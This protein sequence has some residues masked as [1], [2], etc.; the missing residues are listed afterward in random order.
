MAPA[1]ISASRNDRRMLP[2]SQLPFRS[3]LKAAGAQKPLILRA[4]RRL[5]AARA[6]R[7]PYCRA[8]LRTKFRRVVTNVPNQ[9]FR[10][11][12]RTRRNQRRVIAANRTHVHG[13]ACDR[14]HP[15]GMCGTSV[16]I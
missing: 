2:Y 1:D 13:F 16:A 6:A 15:V 7:V 9:R 10:G 5:A 8:P 3:S 14:R 11:G 12:R 4:F